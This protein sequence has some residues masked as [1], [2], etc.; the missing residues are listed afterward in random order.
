MNLSVTDQRVLELNLENSR[1]EEADGIPTLS[2]I[3][4]TN[5]QRRLNLIYPGKHEL[6]IGEEPDEFKVVL[7]I[8]LA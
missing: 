4:L 5:V 7:K 3:G 8:D 2:G 6:S 1:N